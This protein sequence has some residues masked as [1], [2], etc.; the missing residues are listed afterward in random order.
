MEPHLEKATHALEWNRFLELAQSEARTHSGK[1]GVHA[2]SDSAKWAPDLATA[3]MLQQEAQE[4]L[5]LLDRDGLWGPLTDL[6]DPQNQ[7]E[8]LSKGAV[9]EISDL[10]LLRSWT[11]A[12]D[13][14]TQTPRE[15]IRGD[16][17]KKALGS[18]TDPFEPLRILQRVLT[19]EGELSEKASPKLASLYSEIRSL[20]REIGIVLDQLMKTFSQKGVLQE[21]FTDVRDGRYVIPV[22]ISSQGEIDG[23]IY[24]ASAS[25]Q[26]VFVEPREVA[27]LNNRLRQRQNELIQEIY[28]VLED[29]AKRLRPFGAELAA[30]I[31]VIVHWDGVQARGRFGRHYSGKPIDVTEERTFM[32]HQSAHPLLWWS[33]DQ[34]AIIRNQIDFGD[35]VRTLLLTGPNTGGKTVLLK[36]LG[37]AGLCARTG[38]PFPAVDLPTVP[39]FDSFFA[40][41]GDAQSIEQHLSSFSGHILRFKEIL[42]HVTTR[43]LVLIDELNS[44]TDPEEGAALGRAFLETVMARGATIVATT[45]DPHLKAIAVSDARI[46][47][48]SMEFNESSRVPTYHMLLGVPGRSRALETAERLGIPEDVLALARKYLTRE[49]LEFEK[50]LSRLE[51]DSQEAERARKEAVVLRDDAERLKKEWTERTEMSVKEMMDRTRQK[52][53]HILEQAQDEVRA[54]VRKLDETKNR[55]ELDQSRTQMNETF[56]IA[57]HRIETALREEAPQIADA[58]ARTEKDAIAEKPKME[59][60]TG[61]PVRVP[62]WK[63]TGT[64]LEIAGNKVKVAMGAIQVSISISDIEPL[65]ATEAAAIAP[66]KKTAFTGTRISGLDVPTPA[67]QIDLRGKRFDEAMAELEHYLDQA[68]RSGGLAEV[69]VVHGLGTGVLR[70]GARKLIG[71]LPYIK[72]VRDAGSA[73][74]TAVE[75]DRD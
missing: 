59:L 22:K 8:Q 54:N 5:P 67:P 65:T 7:L 35:P 66:R 57:A 34:Q 43:S 69:T 12:I 27:A 4:I 3:R 63:S 48:A 19:P 30:A 24:E 51:Q 56:G 47:N 25:R 42:D 44:S 9:L 60:S 17:F 72:S 52:L 46:L 68:F 21:N 28:V 2:L 41:L 1:A 50:L 32:L 38:L 6:A 55:R 37:L 45:H 18:L 16:R 53:R 70:E 14:W 36:T 15:E 71:K 29:T 10:V 33:L 73:G 13:S 75:F 20:K 26:T 58:L 11:Y 40:D 61:T 64:I 49:H 62:K 23:I 31:E 39:F 74:A